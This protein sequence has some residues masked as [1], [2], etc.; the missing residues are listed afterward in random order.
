MNILLIYVLQK[1]RKVI[2]KDTI[3][4]EYE[5]EEKNAKN[6]AMQFLVDYLDHDPFLEGVTTIK[7][8]EVKRA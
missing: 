2:K 7:I 1:G 8:I 6:D 4:W 5:G 3:T